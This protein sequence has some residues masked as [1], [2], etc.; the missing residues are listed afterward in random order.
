M[1]YRITQY[2]HAQTHIKV[3]VQI[4][5]IGTRKKSRK[6]RDEMKQPIITDSVQLPVNNR[7][8]HLPHSSE[9]RKIFFT[10]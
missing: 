5:E 6:K 10:L 8:L 2:S 1:L 3:K 7:S 9:G 4:N